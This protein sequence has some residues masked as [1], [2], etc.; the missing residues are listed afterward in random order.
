VNCRCGPKVGA[1]GAGYVRLASSAHRRRE[2]KCSTEV[3]DGELDGDLNREELDGAAD[4]SSPG[5]CIGGAQRGHHCSRE[6]PTLGSF[7]FHVGMAVRGGGAEEVDGGGADRQPA[8]GRLDEGRGQRKRG[9]EGGASGSA[10]VGC[11]R[12]SRR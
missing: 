9:A 12:A 3:L 4:G 10:A 6:D 2:R 1:A 8:A 5:T 11:R 7:L